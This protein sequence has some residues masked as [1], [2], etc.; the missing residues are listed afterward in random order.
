[1]LARRDRAKAD[2]D[3]F[4]AASDAD[5]APL[6][7]EALQAAI[8]AYEVLKAKAG[9][10]DFLDLLIKARDLICDNAERTRPSCSTASHTS[11]STSSRTPIPSRP[12]S[13]CC[14]PPTI[15][16][17]PIGAA[18]RP[19]PG[20]LFL[21]GDPKQSIYRF[22]RADVAL[23]E[24]VKTRL[25]ARRR[26]TP[27]SHHQLS[28]SSLDSVVRQWRLCSGHGCWL[29]RQ[30][31]RLCAARARSTGNRRAAD[32]R[33]PAGSEALWRLRKDRQLANR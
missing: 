10:L 12:R 19:I 9:R 13:C 23:Y 18:V 25:L 17:K 4:I 28:R 22:R 16:A 3:A 30:P 32:D 20:K 7:H 31:G 24:E 8:A 2:L 26:G 27:S 29:G 1:M 6:L 14:S 15:P 33:R 21:V 11:L 5:L